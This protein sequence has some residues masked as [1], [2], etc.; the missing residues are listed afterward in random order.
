MY[1][2]ALAYEEGTSIASSGALNTSSGAKKG[3]SPKD[4]RIVDEETSTNDIWWGSVNIKME[5]KTFMIN[6]ERAV[7]YLNT[8]D[9]LYVMDGYAGW[10]PEYR[11]KVRVVCA[12]A[13]HGILFPTI[14]PNTK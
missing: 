1:E 9:R 2:D 14:A 4:K 11:I 8:C 10:D 13:Y 6:R 5:D 3:R 7:D 12:R